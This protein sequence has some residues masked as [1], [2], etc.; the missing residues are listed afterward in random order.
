[1]TNNEVTIEK[2]DILKN[3]Y[4][5]A[6]MTQNAG[7]KGMYGS[8]AGKSDQMGGI[9][10]RWINVVPESV[11]FNKLILPKVSDKKL[12]IIT[13]FYKYNPKQ[14]TT[15]IAPDVLGLR[16]ENKVIPFIIYD[17][18][19]TPIEGMPQIEVKT[20]KKPQQMISLRDQGYSGKYLVMVESNY[21]V[22]YLLPFFDQSYFT[23]TTYNQMTMDDKIFIRSNNNGLISHLKKVDI[24]NK[25]LG[26]LK[27]L[28]ITETQK[29][30]ECSTYCEP[31]VSPIRISGITEIAKTKETESTPLLS[32]CKKI[33]NLYRFMECWYDGLEE[34]TK[35][36]Y[37][38]SKTKSGVLRR[39]LVRLLDFY[40]HKPESILVVKRNKYDFVITSKTDNQFNN[41]KIEANKFY[42]I[43]LT[44]LGRSGSSNGEYFFQKDLISFIPS[45]E[46]ELLNILKRIVKEN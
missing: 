27:L 3:I 12:S 30:E 46:S 28:V 40:C 36:P 21:R 24:S 37:L 29:F 31:N 18:K 6:E 26:T 33:G 35:I 45:K 38:L 15:G 8:L 32:Y 25:S 20:F 13:D 7:E 19:W 44:E 14:E 4:F 41:Y 11:I 5:I 42:K 16:I 2:E 23:D 43:S 39:N 9:F 1:M 34:D 17:E 22:D 10:D